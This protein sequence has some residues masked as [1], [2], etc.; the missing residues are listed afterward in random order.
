MMGLL[1]E[2]LLA[3]EGENQFDFAYIDAD[4]QNYIKYYELCVKLVRSG[5]IV[6][7]DNVG[8]LPVPDVYN[9]QSYAL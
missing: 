3:T 2:N 1:S 5:G 9:T 6:A 8:I 4:K 7:I